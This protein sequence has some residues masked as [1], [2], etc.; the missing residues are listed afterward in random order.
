MPDKNIKKEHNKRYEY[1]RHSEAIRWFSFKTHINENYKGGAG[2]F[3][4]RRA[5]V[6]VFLGENIGHELNGL[7]PAIVVS[8]DATNKTSGN[9]AIVPLTKA[10]NKIRDGR[11][12]LLKTQYLLKRSKYP[13]LKYDSVVLCECIRVVSKARIGDLIGY[14]TPEDMKKIERA[15]RYFLA[16]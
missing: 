9:V 8:L 16:V 15:I 11:I 4:P 7:R 13:V 3:F 10:P 12:K 5:I 14:V 6:N 1:D 2:H